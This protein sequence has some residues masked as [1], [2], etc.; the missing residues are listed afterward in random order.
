MFAHCPPGIPAALSSLHPGVFFSQQKVL[1][2]SSWT[3]SLHKVFN[4]CP[5]GRVDMC[6]FGTWIQ[7]APRKMQGCAYHQRRCFFQDQQC[8]DSRQVTSEMD[9]L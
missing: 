4:V 3:L 8:L 6:P 2:P 9:A 5:R 1:R 7:A